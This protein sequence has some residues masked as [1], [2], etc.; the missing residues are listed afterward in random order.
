MEVKDEATL[1]LIHGALR[2]TTAVMVANGKQ[3]W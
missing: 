2:L 3:R 1:M